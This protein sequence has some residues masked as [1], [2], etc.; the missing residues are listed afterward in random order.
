MAIEIRPGLKMTNFHIYF[1]NMDI[2]LI[3]IVTCSKLSTH[4]ARTH[5][6]GS[7]SQNFD[8]GFSFCFIV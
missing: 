7:V 6:E 5:S 2:S 8:L 1:L 4:D 3:I